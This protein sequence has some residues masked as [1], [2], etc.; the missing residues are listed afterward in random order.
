MRMIS[1]ERIWVAIAVITVGFNALIPVAA[2]AAS[3]SEI[4]RDARAV[5]DETL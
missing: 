3:A 2:L 5:V 1:S 4:D